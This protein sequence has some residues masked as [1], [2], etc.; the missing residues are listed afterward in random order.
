MSGS[1]IDQDISRSDVIGKVSE[2]RSF[3]PDCRVGMRDRR[4]SNTSS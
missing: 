1:L 4:H 3:H 2:T